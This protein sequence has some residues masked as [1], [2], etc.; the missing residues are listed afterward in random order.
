MLK[1]SFGTALLC[2][3][4]L[5]LSGCGGDTHESV[6]KEMIAQMKAMTDALKSVKDKDSA[7]AQAS[8]FKSIGEKLKEIKARGDKLPKLS[9]EEEKAL[10]DKL[11]G[12][13]EPIMKDLM[14][15]MFRVGSL[16]PEVQAELKSAMESLQSLD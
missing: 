7:T 10:E 6:A 5:S 2:A 12:E 1:K 13:M 3:V 9:A 16:G 15:E 11:K 8:T 14:T 4:A